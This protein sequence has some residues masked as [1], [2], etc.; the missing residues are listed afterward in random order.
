MDTGCECGLRLAVYQF[1]CEF[2]VLEV[3][4]NMMSCV[5]VEGEHG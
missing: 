2:G 1:V 5:V 3:R 4:L